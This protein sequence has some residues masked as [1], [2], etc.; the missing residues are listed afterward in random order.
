MSRRPPRSTRTDT[1]FP[2]TTLFRSRLRSGAGRDA[3]N[4]V[5]TAD[6]DDLLRIGPQ[7]QL[8][9]GE[10]AVDDVVVAPDAV[11]DELV[12]A[13]GTD[14]EQRRRLALVDPSGELD[15]DLGAVVA[16]G[17]RPPGRDVAGDGVT[18]RQVL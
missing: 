14:H 5:G 6:A 4:A 16:G 12:V 17:H 10:Q 9:G 18:E 3:G 11:V 1:L 7:A 15:Q 13:C 8:G 2:Y